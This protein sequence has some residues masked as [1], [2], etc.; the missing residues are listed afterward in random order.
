MEKSQLIS[1]TAEYFRAVGK[2]T[3]IYMFWVLACIYYKLILLKDPF[4]QNPS[5]SRGHSRS[6]VEAVLC[7]G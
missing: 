2:L 1:T 6:H 3:S 4:V 5:N 7:G